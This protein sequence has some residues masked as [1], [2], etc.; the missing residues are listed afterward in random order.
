MI[1]FPEPEQVE[2]WKNEW[3]DKRVRVKPGVRPDLA[4]FE[5]KVGRVV[6][7]NCAGRAIL[8]FADGAWYD[9]PDFTE[10]LEVVSSETEAARYNPSINS[11]QALP[12]RQS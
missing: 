5:G 1:R 10:V 2:A 9:C 6:T 11:A 4:R 3:T 7:V 12:T 8:D